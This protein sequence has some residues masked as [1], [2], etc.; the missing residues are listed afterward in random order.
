MQAY[1]ARKVTM[2][3]IFIFFIL[4]LHSTFLF[5]KELI[6]EPYS[7]ETLPLNF[8]AKKNLLEKKIFS[9]SLV[10]STNQN[11][12]QLQ[13]KVAGLHPKTCS[14]ALRKISLY[15][16][17]SEYIGFIKKSFYDEK[18]RNLKFVFDSPLLPFA[19]SLEFELDRI[20]QPGI[21]N[22]VFKTGFLIGLKGTIHVNQ[23][24]NNQCLFYFEANWTGQDTKIP[25]AIFEAFSATLGS[26][27]IE[28]L[29]RISTQY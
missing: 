25:N 14:Y 20:T 26:T 27:G 3:Q 12:Q 18:T 4:A 2:Q 8:H 10:T 11:E 28:N 24:K 22:F 23:E 7:I 9:N 5:S 21:Y 29:I 17:Y 16:K 13:L 15:E 1:G 19:M 6:E